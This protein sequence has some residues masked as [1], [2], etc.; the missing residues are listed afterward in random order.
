MAL[1]LIRAF[2]DADVAVPQQVSVVGFD[3]IPG[4]AH[5]IPGLTTV[6]QDFQSLGRQCIGILLAALV[7][8][9]DTTRPLAPSLVV[10]E[11]T[12]PPPG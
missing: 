9:V 12:A 5:F 10:R 11:S 1:G 8:E 6:E 4:A 2:H 7:G 3:D